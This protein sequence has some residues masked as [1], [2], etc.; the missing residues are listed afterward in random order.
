MRRSRSFPRSSSDYDPRR[1][2]PRRPHLLPG[3]R[4]RRRGVLRELSALFRAGAHALAGDAGLLSEGLHGRRHPLCCV[5]LRATLPLARPLRLDADDRDE[6]DRIPPGE[7]HLR[8]RDP[9]EEERPAGGGRLRPAG[10][11]GH[12]GEARQVAE[13]PSRAADEGDR[14]HLT[15]A[16]HRHVAGYRRRRG[17][18]RDP[19]LSPIQGAGEPE[20]ERVKEQALWTHSAAKKSWSRSSSRSA[21]IKRSGWRRW[22][23]RARSRCL[24]EGACPWGMWPPCSF[25]PCCTMRWSSRPRWRRRTPM[26]MTTSNRRPAASWVLQEAKQVAPTMRSGRL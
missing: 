18:F 12:A 11:R 13:G 21:R 22:S 5:A 19:A 26:R 1:R 6:T 24:P 20:E 9:G 23:R 3:H 8:P 25:A 14:S 16:E 10:R 15:H 17:G 4:L 7:L 2:Y